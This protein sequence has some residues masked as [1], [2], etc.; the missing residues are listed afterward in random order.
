MMKNAWEMI[1]RLVS[2]PKGNYEELP[3][4]QRKLK[5]VWLTVAVDRSYKADSEADFIPLVVFDRTAEFIMRNSQS[6]FEKGLAAM[7]RKG[8]LV[9]AEGKIRTSPYKQN[10]ETIYRTSLVCTGIE[11]L[12][13]AKRLDEVP[14]QEAGSVQQEIQQQAAQP[15]LQYST[16]EERIRVNTQFPFPL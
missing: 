11:P 9:F 8:A 5:N 2:E 6:N 4:G 16:E 3:D 14:Q 13:P 7:F 10:G 15:A 1:G 12:G